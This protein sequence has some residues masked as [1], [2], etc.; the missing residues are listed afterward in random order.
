MSVIHAEEA[1][2]E[3]PP[4]SRALHRKTP[5]GK[6]KWGNEIGSL[7]ALYVH[8]LAIAQEAIARYREFAM[9]VADHGN[10]TVSELFSRL[11]DLEVEHALHVAKKVASIRSPKLIPGEYAWLHSQPLLPEARELI[12]RMLTPR[13][14]LEIAVRAEERAKAF[15]MQ[16]LAAS[17]DAGE[18]ELAIEFG[19]DE[20]SHI[21]WLRDALA[22]V[23]EPFRPSEDC[24]GDP[25]T[26][27]AL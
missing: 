16:V 19:R 25:A 6:R 3:I 24:P 17:D 26:P 15:F 2:Q 12:F 9:H 23:P 20:D 10:D 21:A 27:Q 1:R 22:G 4:V 13:Q 14:A 5:V 7:G 11:A 8:A 18:R